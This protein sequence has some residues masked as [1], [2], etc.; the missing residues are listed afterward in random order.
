MVQRMGKRHLARCVVLWT[1]L[2]GC[3]ALVGACASV[4]EAPELGSHEAGGSRGAEDDPG[5]GP[6]VAGSAVDG[7]A[8]EE[9]GTPAPGRDAPTTGGDPEDAPLDPSAPLAVAQA[10]DTLVVISATGA[11]VAELPA[12]ADLEA[13]RT[14]AYHELQS[15]GDHVLIARAECRDLGP[16]V[17]IVNDPSL[18]PPGSCWQYAMLLR[19]PDFELVWQRKSEPL[20][21]TA[22]LRL[23]EAGAVSIGESSFGAHTPRTIVVDLDGREHVFDGLSP[24]SAPNAEG[25][26]AV[27][28]DDSDL[29]PGYAFVHPDAPEPQRLSVPMHP[30]GPAGRDALII[31]EPQLE[32]DVAFTYLGVDD[33]GRPALVHERPEGATRID[34]GAAPEG[35]TELEIRLTPRAWLLVGYDP[36]TRTRR[37]FRSVTRDDH[38]VIDF[39]LPTNVASWEMRGGVENGDWLRLEDEGEGDFAYGW[40]DASTGSFKHAPPPWPGTR[41]F[42]TD[43]CRSTD[44]V[45]EAGRALVHLRDDA[46]GRAYLEGDYGELSPISAPFIEAVSVHSQQ[47]GE[48]FVFRPVAHTATYCPEPVWGEASAGVEVVRGGQ[49][50]F[51]RGSRSLV[52]DDRLA[53]GMLSPDGR[54]VAEL[55]QDQP[56][57]LHDLVTGEVTTLERIDTFHA[58]L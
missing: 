13:N 49:V 15:V 22:V 51:L 20:A 46:V 47:V 16:F 54:F 36:T 24:L 43:Y 44:F 19:R 37:P 14:A 40:V 27:R 56:P 9:P 1:C 58:W 5:G 57:V 7:P 35:D 41:P 23:G 6:A 25:F 17:A 48:T 52:L 32:H 39:L 33:A 45:T 18:P 55:L 26:I 2:V 50:Q 28:I 8:T 31:T 12:F 10:G 34:L 42:E 30:L 38:R 53:P 21:Y 11:V 3:A 29:A 4:H